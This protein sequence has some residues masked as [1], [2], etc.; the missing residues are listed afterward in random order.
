VSLHFHPFSYGFFGPTRYR[1]SPSLG[2]KATELGQ[3]PA[4]HSGR[5]NRAAVET[6]VRVAVAAEGGMEVLKEAEKDLAGPNKKYDMYVYLYLYLYIYSC[7]L[8]SCNCIYNYMYMYNYIFII[9][10]VTI[11]IFIYV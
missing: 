9:I 10:S 11:Y 4:R 8:H 6:T 1:R 2:V 5:G 7:L 3:P